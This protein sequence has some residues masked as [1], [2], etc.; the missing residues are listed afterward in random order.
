MVTTRLKGAFL[1]L[2]VA[3]AAHS[4]EEF[5]F[6][7]WEVFPPARFLS[8]T[9]WPWNPVIG[10]LIINVGLVMLMIWCLLRVVRPERSSARAWIW[11]FV[12]LEGI[13]GV[14][15]T[16]WGLLDMGYRPGLLTAL[17]FLVLVP[18]L[19]GELRGSVTHDATL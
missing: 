13:N 12:A 11:G 19:V 8:S 7:L 4:T 14:G 16:V 10:F 18:I 15:H 6:E 3:Q 5:L 17:P 1:L 9:V 2:T